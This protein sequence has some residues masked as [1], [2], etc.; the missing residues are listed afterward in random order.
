[1]FP[2]HLR[3]NDGTQIA[4]NM[5]SSRKD[6]LFRPLGIT[7]DKVE[8]L[9]IMLFNKVI[10][11]IDGADDLFQAILALALPLI[12]FLEVVRIGDGAQRRRLVRR[13]HEELQVAA[14][15]VKAH[16]VGF[17]MLLL[18]IQPEVLLQA[19]EGLLHWLKGVNCRILM[20]F[21]Q[22]KAHTPNIR[23]DVENRRASGDKAAYEINFLALRTDED[24]LRAANVL[25]HIKEE[26]D[27]LCFEYDAV[28]SDLDTFAIRIL[29][30]N[31]LHLKQ[32]H[33]PLARQFPIQAL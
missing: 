12:S 21:R 15:T 8:T 23:S 18:A 22:A 24:R 9:D 14:L 4:K 33:E 11:R 17:Y 13:R 10:E 16:V 29:L 6:H 1:M 25:R 2:E 7:F 20:S 27:I 26:F 28:L 31:L 30:D 32:R 3:V 5:Y 19:V